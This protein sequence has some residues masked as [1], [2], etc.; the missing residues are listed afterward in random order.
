M[1]AEKI[2]SAINLADEKYLKEIGNS[3]GISIIF[4]DI[5]RKQHINW[6]STKPYILGNAAFILSMLAMEEDETIDSA[7]K[8]IEEGISK[9]NRWSS[10]DIH[11][12][13]GLCFLLNKF[14]DKVLAEK[15]VISFSNSTG[16]L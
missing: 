14:N 7:W 9:V 8:F 2:E 6:S 10:L 4:N 15:V 3:K 5:I 16:I 11:S 1:L 13:I 12:S